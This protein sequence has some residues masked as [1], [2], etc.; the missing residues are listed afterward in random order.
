MNFKWVC[1]P[2]YSKT[3]IIGS[4][5]NDGLDKIYFDNLDDT[6]TIFSKYR[7]MYYELENEGVDYAI[8]LINEDSERLCKAS[9]FNNVIMYAYNKALLPVNILATIPQ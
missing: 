8:S 7:S 5:Y 4:K 2:D 3:L 1:K 6:K 9:R